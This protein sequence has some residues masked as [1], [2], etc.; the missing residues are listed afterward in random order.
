MGYCEPRQR[1]ILSLSVKQALKCLL[2]QQSMPHRFFFIQFYFFDKIIF[3]NDV[4]LSSGTNIENQISLS[5]VFE[6]TKASIWE[7]CHVQYINM[8]NKPMDCTCTTNL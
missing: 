8:Y 2:E 7:I 5:K 4:Y 3:F 6:T 1:K